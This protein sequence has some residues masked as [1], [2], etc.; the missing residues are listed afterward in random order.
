MVSVRLV[1]PEV[2]AA[3]AQARRL[4][5]LTAQQ[6]RTAARALDE[7]VDELDI[8]EIDQELARRAG[9]LAEQR[10]LR[11]YDAVH[12]AGAERLRDPDLVIVAG[13]VALLNAAQAESI[14]VAPL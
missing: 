4:G 12:L 1:H 3:I 2:R 13:D 7:R 11:G 10:D 8:I 14:A 9:E 6:L 5:R